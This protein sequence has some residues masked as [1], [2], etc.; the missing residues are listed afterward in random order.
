MAGLGLPVGLNAFRINPHW[1]FLCDIFGHFTGPWRIKVALHLRK[2][3]FGA[4]RFEGDT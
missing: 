3:Y 2:D 4:N 1:Q